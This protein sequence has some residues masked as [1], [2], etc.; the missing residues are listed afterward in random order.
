MA[1]LCGTNPGP[2]PA[3]ELY[4]NA[5]QLLRRSGSHVE[6][7]AKL[8]DG[9]WYQVRIAIDLQSK[10]YKERLELRNHLRRLPDR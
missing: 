3:V 4:F 6:S 7:V 2:S 10:T 9:V 5:E 8:Q 1:I